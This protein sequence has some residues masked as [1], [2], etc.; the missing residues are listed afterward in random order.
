M[1]IQLNTLNHNIVTNKTLSFKN[2]PVK[3]YAYNNEN[4]NI[5]RKKT[6][7][8][9]LLGI[10]TLGTTFIIAGKKG[11]LGEKIKDI[12]SKIIISSNN[13]KPETPK[14]LYHLTNDEYY[15]SIM[16]D[17]FI[18]KSKP[19]IGNGIFMSNIEDLKF[20]YP[21]KSIESMFNWYSE[22]G[23]KELV[24]LEIPVENLDSNK[25]NWRQISLVESPIKPK[26]QE[27]NK[28]KN[29]SDTNLADLHDKPLEFLYNDV[30]EINNITKVKRFK[31]S[32]VDLDN[33][34]KFL[35]ELLK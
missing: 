35:D 6:I 31:L 16:S 7:T 32:E 15:E 9:S 2:K 5:N 29:F 21:K 19:D 20:K 18:K 22:N 17:K 28:L 11:F 12:L 26:S 24:L 34:A 8:Y 3:E 33:V 14:K 4:K 10:A 30:I 27:W 13:S 1:R 25:I 23:N